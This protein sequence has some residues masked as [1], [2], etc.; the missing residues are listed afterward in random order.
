MFAFAIWDR[1]RRWLLLARDRFGIKPLYYATRR[2]ARLRAPSSTPC[3]AA[4][5]DLAAVEEFLVFGT[6]RGRCSIF[7][8]VRQLPPAHLLRLDAGDVAPDRYCASG[9]AATSTTSTRRTRRGDAAPTCAIGALEPCLRR[10]GRRAPDRRRLL[11][12]AALAAEESRRPG[13]HVLDRVRRGAVQ[14]T[15]G[16][17]EAA[18]RYGTRAPRARPP[19]RRGAPAA[20]LA[21]AFDEP[22]ADSS[23]VPTYLVSRLAAGA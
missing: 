13:A 14:R 21:H 11:R 19:P 15:P 10:P 4:R 8:G 6:C 20:G 7:R 12:V 18:R 2:R 16:A 9:A 3:R 5:V 17:A 22:F 23:A 1:A